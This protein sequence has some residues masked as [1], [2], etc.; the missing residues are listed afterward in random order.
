MDAMTFYAMGIPIFLLIVVVGALL[1]NFLKV[2]FKK[3]TSELKDITELPGYLNDLFVG[4]EKELAEL[5]FEFSHCQLN[6]KPFVIPYPRDWMKVYFNKKETTCAAVSLSFAPDPSCPCAIEFITIFS[7]NQ[8]LSTVNGSSHA[9][10]GTIPDTILLDPYTV[11]LK[12]QWECHLKGLAKLKQEKFS[13]SQTPAEFVAGYAKGINDYVDALEQKKWLKKVDDNEYQL[14][15][16]AAFISCFKVFSGMFKY[17]TLQEK[18]VKEYKTRNNPLT[19][20]EEVEIQNFYNRTEL[21]KGRKQGRLKIVLLF[22]ITLVLFSFSFG[23]SIN[24]KTILIL[25]AVIFFH[26]LGHF[27]GMR[28]FGQGNSKILFIPFIGAATTGMDKNIPAHQKI[29]IY[30]LGPLLG[31]ILG[32]FLMFSPA[33][34]NGLFRQTAI[35]L[36][37]INYF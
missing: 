32:L 33:I 25:I 11:S 17:Q 35:F 2:R 10:I 18:R 26:E 37:F 13:V 30:F 3:G 16:S 19:L 8:R 5:G 34:H 12:G 27:W 9:I 31:I 29:V 6:E 14:N 20:P 15:F 24:F 36:L 4:S 28:I 21:F 1:N 22:L 23:F 7:D